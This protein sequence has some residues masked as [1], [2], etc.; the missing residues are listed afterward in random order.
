MDVRRPTLFNIFKRSK[1]ESAHVLLTHYM[2]SAEE[3]SIYT[4]IENSVEV[5][6][7]DSKDL[8]S[9]PHIPIGRLA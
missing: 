8:V 2:L 5:P 1:S 7:I 9:F 3:T 6:T 4:Q